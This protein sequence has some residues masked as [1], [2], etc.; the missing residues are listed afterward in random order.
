[1]TTI[2]RV[3]GFASNEI[4]CDSPLA[5]TRYTRC[6]FMVALA[7][8][9]WMITSWEQYFYVL[10][11]YWSTFRP[12]GVH[13]LDINWSVT[14]RMYNWRTECLLIFVWIFEC[15]YVRNVW[16]ILSLAMLWLDESLWSLS[17]FWLG[18]PMNVSICFITYG[19]TN[20][21]Y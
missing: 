5:R 6:L 16:V 13:P 10:I 17:L 20:M 9:I 15:T 7:V 2:S 4:S 14:T 21:V 8:Y 19:W 12:Y 1:M 11:G 3:W 18:K